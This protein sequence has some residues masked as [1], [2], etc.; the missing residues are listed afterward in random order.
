M[1]CWLAGWLA[2]RL[3]LFARLPTHKQPA[4]QR[5]CRYRCY[6]CHCGYYSCP[7]SSSCPDS[8]H[9]CHSV[10]RAAHL[11]PSPL[12]SCFTRSRLL[13]RPLRPDLRPFPLH[14]GQPVHSIQSTTAHYHHHHNPPQSASSPSSPPRPSH[15]LTTTTHHHYYYYPPLHHRRQNPITATPA[16]SLICPTPSKLRQSPR[17]SPS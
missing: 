11:F 12:S 9:C 1:A 16:A 15:V 8:Y 5:R 10:V 4:S 7:S 2:A 13:A 3:R 6:C 17:Q 14:A